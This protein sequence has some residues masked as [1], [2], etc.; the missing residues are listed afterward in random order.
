MKE[1]SARIARMNAD[2]SVVCIR[3]D[4]R[5]SASGGLSMGKENP[6]R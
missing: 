1:T 5:E 4:L 2:Q 3:L 6:C